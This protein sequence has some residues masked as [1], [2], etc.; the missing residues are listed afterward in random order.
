MKLPERFKRLTIWNKLGVF[1]AIASLVGLVPLFFGKGQ[2]SVEP[3]YAVGWHDLIAA[4][5]DKAPKLTLT[6]GGTEYANVYIARIAI[7]NQGRHFMD[8]TLMSSTDP[9]RVV[10]PEGIKVL[11][12]QI[13]FTSRSSLNLNARTET[14]HGQDVVVLEVV[15]D[16]ALEYH[17]GGILNVT[18]TKTEAVG[19]F[20]QVRGPF[21]DSPAD[22]EVK[23]RVKGS[24]NGFRRMPFYDVTE[25]KTFK[26]IF[27]SS[28]MF[29]F[30]EILLVAFVSTRAS[31]K[32]GNPPEPVK[33]ARPHEVVLVIVLFVFMAGCSFFLSYLMVSAASVEWPAWVG[34]AA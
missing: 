27:V 23:G 33:P 5:S 12:A 20:G 6:W 24:V 28:A 4:T 9:I 14:Y 22:F 2:P 21:P 25:L 17:E 31:P 15:G 30:L 18:Y 13:A 1:G 29:C 26:T 16:D 34:R 10:Y 19:L 8:K 32:P 3:T 11:S 7:W